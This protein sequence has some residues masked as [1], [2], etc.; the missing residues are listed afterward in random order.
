MQT[1]FEFKE[2]IEV[3]SWAS[4]VGK[5]EHDGPLGRLF[6]FWDETDRFGKNTWELAESELSHAVLALALKRAGLSHREVAFLF[7]GD[8]QNQCVA[9]SAAHVEEEIPFLGIYGACSTC[10]EG[11]LLS[12][13]MLN[14][15]EEPLVG[16]AVTTSHNSAAERQFRTPIEYG[17][18]RSPT[19]QWTA[20]AGGAFLLRRGEQHPHI[21][22]AMPGIMV[23]GGIKDASNMGAAMAPAAAASILS[24]LRLT[25]TAPADYDAIVTGDLGREGSALLEMLLREKGVFLGDRHRDCGNM[26]YDPKKSDCH[27][28]GSGC[29]CSAAVLAGHFLPCLAEG[30]YRRILFLSTGA[31]MSPAS[32]QQGGSIIGVAPVIE[33]VGGNGNG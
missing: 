31:L 4:A 7:S 20:T 14:A 16:A 21:V 8:L 33:L 18:Q 27:A 15:A 9:S 5:S 6:D 28:G 11:L 13:V 12:A 30:E 24:Y 29:G 2:K 22:R 23:D 1:V 3:F 32:I 10:T 26:M 19:A 25:G 17:G